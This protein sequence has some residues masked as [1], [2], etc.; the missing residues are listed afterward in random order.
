MEKTKLP[1]FIYVWLGVISGM[2]IVIIAFLVFKPIGV[3]HFER[4][5]VLD[6]EYE[7]ANR[8][9]VV[10]TDPQTVASITSILTYDMTVNHNPA[11]GIKVEFYAI[12]R[13]TRQ[14]ILS[15]AVYTGTSNA[16]G[17]ISLTQGIQGRYYYIKAYQPNS[18]E[19]Y[20]M[21]MDTAVTLNNRATM[22]V[23]PALQ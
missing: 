9:V 21:G 12:D 3:P 4:H 6:V 1:A 8:S 10:N 19:A 22:Q 14:P 5:E 16:A 7:N 17:Q 11:G 13:E 23:P 15:Q 20:W 18:Q 2:I